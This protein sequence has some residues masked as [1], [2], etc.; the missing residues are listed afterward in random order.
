[1]LAEASKFV[2][3]FKDNAWKIWRADPYMVIVFVLFGFAMGKL[4]DALMPHT[5]RMA[6]VEQ[7]KREL[8]AEASAKKKEN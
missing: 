6:A 1:M 4:L 3:S 8:S 2:M 7:A 5:S